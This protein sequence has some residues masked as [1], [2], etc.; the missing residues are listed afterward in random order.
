MSD[1]TTDLQSAARRAQQ[2]RQEELAAAERLDI[3]S[4]A[5]VDA[6]RDWAPLG[7]IRQLR[8][9]QVEAALVLS[10]ATAARLAADSRRA[11]LVTMRVGDV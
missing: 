2:A 3:A 5:L 1:L 6:T 9:T 8:A 11:A 7:T 10:R 4:R